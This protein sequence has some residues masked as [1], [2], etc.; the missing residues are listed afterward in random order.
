MILSHL[1]SLNVY[2][3]LNRLIWF[4]LLFPDDN[5]GS[6]WFPSQYSRPAMF[7]IGEKEGITINVVNY[8]A[9]AVDPLFKS[10]GSYLAAVNTSGF[11]KE[12]HYAFYM[13]AYNYLAV[14]TVRYLGF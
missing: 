13:N 4:F 10:F 1:Y 2:R 7:S 6:L 11:T 8:S 9:M 5:F 12:Q 14:R 3:S